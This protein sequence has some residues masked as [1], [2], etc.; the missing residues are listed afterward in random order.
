[1]SA[2]DKMRNS[3]RQLSGRIKRNAG[4]VTGNAQLQSEGQSEE[5]GANAAQAG[6]KLKDAARSL[7]PRRR[8]RRRL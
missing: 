4:E 6:E 1:M 5:M 2:V 3:A 8:R 7:A